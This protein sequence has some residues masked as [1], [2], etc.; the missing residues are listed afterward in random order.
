MICVA[1]DCDMVLGKRPLAG[2]AM[3]TPILD[4][5][6]DNGGTELCG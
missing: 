2:C 3:Q 1:L 4:P 6:R 5:S